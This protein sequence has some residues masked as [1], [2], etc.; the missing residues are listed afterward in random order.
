L[1]GFVR[2]YQR[3]VSSGT[4]TCSTQLSAAPMK[5]EHPAVSN[6]FESRVARDSILPVPT[7]RLYRGLI[8]A[9]RAQAP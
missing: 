3:L 2:G 4:R 6:H 9:S 8:M 1:Q 7:T 5:H